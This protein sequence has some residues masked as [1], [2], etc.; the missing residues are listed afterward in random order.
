[1][2]ILPRGLPDYVGQLRAETFPFV[3]IDYDADAP[4]CNVINAANRDGTPERDR[5]TLDR[6]VVAVAEVRP[7][8]GQR[9]G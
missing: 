8:C 3:L 4:G 9:A 7:V 5:Q 1:M 2:I 6:G